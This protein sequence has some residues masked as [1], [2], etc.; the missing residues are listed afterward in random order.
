M[1]VASLIAVVSA[2]VVPLLPVGMI[3]AVLPLHDDYDVV[4]LGVVK[5]AMLLPARVASEPPEFGGSSHYH[6]V[7]YTC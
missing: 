2:R 4:P 1:C 3:M 5:L 7:S 6:A